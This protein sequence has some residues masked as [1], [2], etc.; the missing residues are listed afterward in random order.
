MEAD[1]EPEEEKQI[2][3]LM[4]LY[5]D[6]VGY[7]PGAKFKVQE[8]H[9]CSEEGQQAKAIGPP[10]VEHKPRVAAQQPLVP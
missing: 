1:I 8:C 3:Q 7:V 6:R 10:L 2:S 5:T 9:Q 4:V